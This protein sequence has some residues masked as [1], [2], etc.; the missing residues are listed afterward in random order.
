MTTLKT[1]IHMHT[2][3]SPDSITSIEHF[4][5][6]CL[7]KGLE[8]IAITDHNTIDGAIAIRDISPIP[9][10][11]GEEVKSRDGDIIG[12]FLQETVPE[13][14][15]ALETVKIIKSQG[16][17][18]SIPHPFDH[19]RRLV[20]RKEALNEI[21]NY[22]DIIEGFNAR[23]T[24]HKDNIS[25]KNFASEHNLLTASVSD[26]HT[27]FEIGNTYMD[28]PTFDNNP[29]AFLKNLP[30]AKHITNKTTPLIHVLTT[31]TRNYKKLRRI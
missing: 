30:K 31:L 13:G 9:V 23:N 6:K 16:G 26:S 5:M 10:I 17:I 20:I 8:C 2:G 7:E 24:L 28:I 22:V 29:S 25:A 3:F 4:M 21:V 18:V 15:S 1:D 12:L 27:L 19:F 14:L 11:I